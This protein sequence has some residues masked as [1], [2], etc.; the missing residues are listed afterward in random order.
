MSARIATFGITATGKTGHP[1]KENMMANEKKTTGELFEFEPIKGFP[2]LNWRGKRPFRSTQYYPAQPKETHGEAVNGWHNEIYWGDNLQVMSHLLKKYRGKVKLVYIDP[3]FDSK[4]DYK[5]KIELKGGRV[6]S[7]YT[8]FEEKQYG[9]IWTNDEYLQFMYE[10]F[11]MLRELLADDGSIYVHMD[12]NRSHYIKI[13]LDEVF[14]QDNFQREIIW[15]IGWI[16]GYKSVAKNYIR[17]HDIIFYYSKNSSPV[18]NKIYIPYADD[19]VRRDGKKPDGPGYPIEDTWNC[20]ELDRLDSIQI[21][22]FSGEKVGY[23]TQK[24][25]NLVTRIVNASSNP[26]DI[27]LD[28]FMGSGTAQ[29]VAMKLGRKFIGADINLGAIQTTTKRLLDVRQEITKAP[30]KF[31]GNGGEIDTFYTGFKVF[32]VNHYDVF[33]NPEEAKRILLEAYGIQPLPSGTMFDGELDGFMVKLMPVNRIATRADLNEIVSNVDRKTLS[34][35]RNESPG[36]PQERILLICMGHEPDLAAV[37]R[38]EFAKEKYDV[39]VKVADVLKDK[40]ELE[41]K[42]ESEAKVLR[43]KDRLVIER[44]Y[45]MNLLQKLS[46]QKKDVSDWRDL[47]DSVMIDWDWNSKDFRPTT[48]DIPSGKS[49]VSGEYPVP[50]G[51]K[52]IKV[53]ITDLLAESYEVVLD[54]QA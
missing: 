38:Q 11:I 15:R 32:T 2:L 18:F 5:K 31:K 24:N 10:R 1:D 50:P 19:Y 48:T 22:S 35:R 9:D 20:S 30:S 29:A 13:I 25:E 21:M 34:R 54:G 49:L 36:E 37:L 52:A 7:E 12:E 16:S 42:R 51:A 27:V 14:G 41:F 33:R 26:G 23:P 53:K 47:V 3:P 6:E 8:P 17:N 44:F 4:A 40:A 39:E 28:C 46:W 45:P 43:K